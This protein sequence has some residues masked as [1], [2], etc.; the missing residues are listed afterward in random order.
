MIFWHLKPI[1]VEDSEKKTSLLEHPCVPQS[2]LNILLGVPYKSVLGPLLF[3]MF[4]FDLLYIHKDLDYESL[5]NSTSPNTAQKMKL[6]I[7]DFFSK[8]DQFHKKL[9]KS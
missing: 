8:C 1:H 2:K 9:K 5:T 4:L 6:S 3:T 7:N